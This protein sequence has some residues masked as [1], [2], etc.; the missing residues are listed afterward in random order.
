MLEFIFSSPFIFIGT[1]I[2]L[3]VL[4]EVVVEIIKSLK[5]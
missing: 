2:L 3:Y 4:G 5:K 1:V